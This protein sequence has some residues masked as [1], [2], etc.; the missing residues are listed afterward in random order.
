MTTSTLTTTSR[1]WLLGASESRGPPALKLGRRAHWG[2][3]ARPR[4]AV[5]LERPSSLEEVLS[6]PSREGARGASRAA[7]RVT[8]RFSLLVSVKLS[9]GRRPQLT[10]HAQERPSQATTER[11]SRQLSSFSFSQ[12]A[13]G[14]AEAR[15]NI[16]ITIVLRRAKFWRVNATT[17]YVQVHRVMRDC[18][19]LEGLGGLEWDFVL[20]KIF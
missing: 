4:A 16:V 17:D 6:S 3:E 8:P 12:Q 18:A 7:S 5:A 1:Q 2:C 9:L 10:F 11:A 13:E 19:S 15:R 14:Q 20:S